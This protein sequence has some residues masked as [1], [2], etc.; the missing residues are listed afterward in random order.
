MDMELTGICPVVPVVFNGQG[1]LDL[2]GSADCCRQLMALG[3]QG[4]VLGAPEGEGHKLDAEEERRLLDAI[5]GT[6]H[7]GGV[8]VVAANGRQGTETACRWARQLQEAGADGMLLV[9]PQA[10]QPDADALL[11]HLGDVC[12]AVSLPVMVQD[13]PRLSPEQLAQLAA[14][15]GNVR[16]IKVD[17]LPQ[18]TTISRL[19]ELL[20]PDRGV[21]VGNGGLHLLVAFHL[22]CAGVLPGPA[23]TDVCR[24][25]WDALLSGDYATAQRVGDLLAAFLAHV[26]QH[27]EM[28]IHF[29]KLILQRRGLIA[30]AR[31]RRPAYAPDPVSDLLFEQ[32]LQKLAPEFTGEPLQPR[33]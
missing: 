28:D 11:H 18:A 20:P 29:Q 16:H 21:F 19:L 27:D 15:H 33:D 7:Q 24:K 32:L 23:V 17:R 12:A 30:S 26:R 13:D 8:P 4:L 31:C 10:H 5:V 14:D 2:T 6:A 3:A 25:V 9:A 1:E 22:G